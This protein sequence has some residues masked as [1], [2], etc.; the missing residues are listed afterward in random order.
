MCCRDNQFVVPSLLFLWGN[1]ACAMM[2]NVVD[3]SSLYSSGELKVFFFD[4]IDLE[5]LKLFLNS[6]L[7]CAITDPI[8][9]KNRNM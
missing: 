9:S 5:K 8:N 1:V 2:G 3:V 7:F 4:Y 6:S